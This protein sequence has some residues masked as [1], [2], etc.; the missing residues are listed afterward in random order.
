MRGLRA[1]MLALRSAL[2]GK[3]IRDVPTGRMVLQLSPGLSD[4]EKEL[5]R[6]AAAVLV[7]VE[8]EAARLRLALRLALVEGADPAVQLEA[9]RAALAW[10]E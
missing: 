2:P 6:A 1:V 10:L 7:E 9:L 3:E 4:K 5:T 8:A